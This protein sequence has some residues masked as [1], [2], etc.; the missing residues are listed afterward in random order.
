[1]IFFESIGFETM[2]SLIQFC[3]GTV[4]IAIETTTCN[5]FFD[6]ISYSLDTFI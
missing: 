5:V 1:M 3:F 6:A 2:K 4:S